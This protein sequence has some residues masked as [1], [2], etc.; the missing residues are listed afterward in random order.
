MLKLV[1]L[2]LLLLLSFWGNDLSRIYAAESRPNILWLTSEDHGPHMGCYGDPIAHTPNVDA[3]AARGMLFKHAWS[4]AP[5]CAPAR[6]TIITGMYPP[7]LGAEH[8]RSQVPMPAGLALFPQLLRQAGYYCSNHV[9]EDYNVSK[10]GR[11][12]D[13]S[14]RKA[15]WK[16]RQAGQPFFAVFNAEASHESKIRSRPHKQVLD[17]AKVRIPAY[18]PDTP[19]VR[20]DWA[21][22]YDQV[23]VA[24]AVAGE[25]LQRLKADG[26]EDNTIV[27]YF[28]DHGSGMPRNKRW[29]GNSGMQMPMV[30]YFP[31]Q[32]RHLAPREYQPGGQSDRLVSFVDLAPTVLSLAGVEPPAWMQGHAFAGKFQQ[33]PQPFVYGFRSRMDERYDF[34]RSATDGRYVYVRNYLPHLST[35]QHVSYQFETPT[36]QVW[37]R[38]FDAGKLNAEQSQFWIA[39]RA[40]EELYDLQNDRD[41]VHNLAGSKEH[42]SVL[43]R[44]RQAQQELA[45]RIRDT[46]FLTEA[47]VHQRSGTTSPRDALQTDKAYPFEEI[48]AAAN[49][50]ST[51]TSSE[52]SDADQQRIRQLLGNSDSGVRYWGAMSCVIR[53]T[54]AVSDFHLELTQALKAPSPSVRIAAAEALGRYGAPADL[55]LVLEVL[56]ECADPTRTSAY[57]ATAAMNVIDNL[58]EKANPLHGFIQT[59]PTRDPQATP[60]GNEYVERMRKKILG[61]AAMEKVVK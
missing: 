46:G 54:Q 15:D 2:G 33:A 49:F 11:V 19:E 41:E 59:M 40:S 7:S 27:F 4:C 39:P 22:Y 8:M 16:N 55:P 51:P 32:W 50:A 12:W 10:P 26:L 58:G 14:S 56:K 29:P 52:I 30:V 45:R 57:A 35:A 61:A 3:L 31:P 23:S 37:K 53:G 13:E 34:A 17:P 36:T 1:R 24:D 38:L 43:E 28:A 47:E 5:V 60:R 21:Q 20:Q 6:T 44:L 25:H 42:Q 18:H 9:K 48:F